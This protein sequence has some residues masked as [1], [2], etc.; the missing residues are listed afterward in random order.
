MG[1]VT[2]IVLAAGQGKRMNSSVAKQFLSLQEKPVVYYSLQAFEQSSVDEIILVT[3]EGQVDYCRKEI[4]EFYHLNKV[5]AIVEGGKERYDSVY[6]GL[7]N[8]DTTDY[9]L[10]HDGARPFITKELI[11]QLIETVKECNACILGI[12]VKDT[13]KI[14]DEKGNITA[15]PD[16]NT[17]WAA[18]TPQAFEYSAIRR[19]FETYYKEKNSHNITITDDAMLYEAFCKLPVKMVTGSYN[20]IKLTTPEDLILAEW[21][22]MQRVDNTY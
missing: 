6:Q 20:N 14:V 17:L 22:L 19:A 4:V 12:P 9:V 15:T 13:I 5:A 3:G 7:I 2:A 18:Q 16:R 21:I 11:N 8:S 10:I 1:K